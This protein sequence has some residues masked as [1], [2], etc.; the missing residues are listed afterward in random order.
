ML[1]SG[2]GTLSWPCSKVVQELQ[3]DRVQKWVRNS[4]LT[5]FKSGSGTLSCRQMAQNPNFLHGL[6]TLTECATGQESRGGRLYTGALSGSGA[7]WTL[8]MP[9]LRSFWRMTWKY[10]RFLKLLGMLSCRSMYLYEI[11][12]KLTEWENKQLEKKKTCE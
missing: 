11:K 5:V 1:K 9:Y 7:R 2:S 4:K 8:T 3:A 12:Y 10:H 6:H